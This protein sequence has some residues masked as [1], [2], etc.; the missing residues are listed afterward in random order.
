M[1]QE[2]A[3]HENDGASFA[4]IPSEK[5]LPIR[6]KCMIQIEVTPKSIRKG[7]SAN[8]LK[9]IA[10]LA[11]V[12]AHFGHIFIPYEQTLLSTINSFINNITAPIIFYFLVVGYRNTRNANRY[13]LRMALLAVISYAPFIMALRGSLPNAGNFLTLNVG[14]TLFLGLCLLRVQHEVE[15]KWLKYLITG[16]LFLFSAFGDWNYRALL[17]VLI[18]DRYYDDY[19]NQVF[20]FVIFALSSDFLSM[21]LQPFSMLRYGAHITLNSTMDFSIYPHVISE[22]GRFFSI[23]LLRFYD[24]SKGKGGALAKY[25]FYIIYPLHLLILGLL[26][27]N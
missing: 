9:L 20:V 6:E 17:M 8:A 5:N 3:R 15:E 23:W 2:E 7:L 4:N 22:L 16:L 27:M 13:M 18:F 19:K 1:Q 14:F 25:G 10:I 12:V 24:G 26:Q 11:M 21:A